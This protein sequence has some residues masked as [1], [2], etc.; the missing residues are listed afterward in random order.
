MI[1]GIYGILTLGLQLNT[2]FTG[3]LNFG[4]AGYMAIG[5]YGAGILVAEAGFSLWLAFSTS[6]VLSAAVAMVIG[7][8]TSRLG[9]DQFAIVTIAFA[10]IVRHIL[11]NTDFSGGN[12]GLIG[13]DVEWRS[14][15]EWITLLFS[16]IGLGE[17][18]QIPLLL[19]VWITF[20]ALTG[21]MKMLERTPWSRVLRGIRDDETAIAALGKNTLWF[22]MQSLAIG[23]ALAVVAGF[24]IALDVTYLYPGIF[25]PTFTF[26]GFVILLIGG[27]G[28][29]WGIMLGSVVFWTLMEGSRLIE[30][31]LSATEQASLRFLVVG[32]LLIVLSRVCPHGFLGNSRGRDHDH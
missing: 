27:L 4:Q 24:F 11:Q 25:D 2:G 21:L 10:E 19:F 1:A 16:G 26:F 14:A 23:A 9:P 29:Y 5:A 22:R 12:Q 32:F 17:Y 20:V 18:K 8:S 13:F 3:L 28:N 31:S 6:L 7:W 15:S 30:T